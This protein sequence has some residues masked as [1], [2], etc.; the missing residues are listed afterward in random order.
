MIRKAVPLA[1]FVV[2]VSL[3]VP[4]FG[5][6]PGASGTAVQAGRAHGRFSPQKGK[7]FVLVIGS[8]ARRGNPAARADALHLVGLNTKTGKGGILNFP[9]DSWVPIPGSGSARINEAL[10]R[11]GPELQVR[12]VERLTGIRIDYWVLT[13]FEGFRNMM[14]E[15]RGVGM[16]LPYAIYDPYGSG[17]RLKAGRQW[18]YAE[19]LLQFARA[20]KT[21]RGGDIART[22]NQAR[23]MLAL[24]KKFRAK[25][26][27]NP[28]TLLRWMNIGRRHT[29]LDISPAEL[30]RL[31]IAASQTKPRNV[32]SVTVPVSIGSVGSASVVFIQSGA[33]S[34]YAR[35]RRTGRL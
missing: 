23:I 16:K 27:K 15:I 11:G 6:P 34:I 21:I 14:R 7:V 17:A 12:T 5:R 26:A 9:R 3:L 19:A 25:V 31:A 28:A 1:A 18:M 30:F 33:R 4:L 20:R 10:V 29:R 24:L 22:G 32:G 13:G 2:A 8:D 35:F